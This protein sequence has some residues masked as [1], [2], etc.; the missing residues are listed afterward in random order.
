MNND[1]FI[2]YKL[3]FVSNSKRIEVIYYVLHPVSKKLIRRRVS[4]MPYKTRKD[5]LRHAQKMMHSINRKLEE[6]WNPFMEG[7]RTIKLVEIEKAFDNI[8]IIKK[9]TVEFDTYRTYRSRIKIFQDW[10]NEKGWLNKLTID[11]TEEIAQRFS[12]YL[13]IEKQITARTH[14]NY[15]NDFINFFNALLKRNYISFNPF[16]NITLLQTTEK[17]KEH[18]SDSEF[19][20]LKEELK[21]KSIGFQICCKLT[22][23]CAMRNKEISKLKIKDINLKERFIRIDGSTSKVKR[24]RTIPIIDQ[25][26]IDELKEFTKGYD[27][28]YF[29]VSHNFIPSKSIDIG[30]SKKLSNHF[31]A[32]AKKLN[33]R[34]GV[35]YYSLKDTLAAQLVKEKVNIKVIQLLMGHSKVSMTENYLSKYAPDLTEH[36]KGKIKLLS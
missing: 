17:I 3:A 27:E 21:N 29:L 14:N 2:N 15:I 23:Y 20:E 19:I 24:I 30:L 26:F 36:I 22:Y 13:M 31:S 32:I 7:T 1:Q 28:N 18:L 34:K 11:I 10:L 5:N 4:S 25:E 6:G 12:D 33:F 16:Q 35:S 9:A 8:L